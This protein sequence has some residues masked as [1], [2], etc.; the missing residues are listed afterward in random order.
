M[1]VPLLF[2]TRCWHRIHREEKE[3]KETRR[4]GGVCICKWELVV[5]ANTWGQ[6]GN[7]MI[8]FACKSSAI[9]NTAAETQRFSIHFKPEER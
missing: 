6:G 7:K 1:M 8:S 5:P 2:C 9:D 4:G 3:G